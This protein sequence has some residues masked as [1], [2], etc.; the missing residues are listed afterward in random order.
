MVAYLTTLMRLEKIIE[1]VVSDLFLVDPYLDTEFAAR[2]LKTIPAQICIRLLGS[3][4]RELD[5][6]LAAVGPLGQQ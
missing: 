3:K 2:Y 6:L 5:S 1:T 4:R